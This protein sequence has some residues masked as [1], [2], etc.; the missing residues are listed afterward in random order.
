MTVEINRQRLL[1]AVA[2]TIQT[3]LRSELASDRA[4]AVSAAAE[5]LLLRERAAATLE[6]QGEAARERATSQSITRALEQVR[7]TPQ[8]AGSG[9]EISQT[10]TNALALDRQHYAEF[11]AQIDREA[12]I[13]A[14][15]TEA[16]QGAAPPVPPTEAGLLA[17]L[18]SRFPDKETIEVRNL[19]ALQGGFSKQTILFDVSFD[20]K[21][22]QLVMRRD[23]PGG[24]VGTT[25]V[26]EFDLLKALYGTGFAI[27]EPL[28]LERDSAIIPY[29]FLV[30]RRVPGRIIGDAVGMREEVDFDPFPALARELARLHS[31]DLNRLRV[32]GYAPTDFSRATL[33]A[34]VEHWAQLYE[35]SVVT[36]CAALNIAIAW[37]RANIDVGLQQEVVLV[38][39]DFGFHNILF[40]GARFAALVDWELAHP[41]SPA[42]D[43]AYI[44]P[45]VERS[46]GSFDGFLA[47]YQRAGGAKVTTEAL[48]FYEML[49]YVRNAAVGTLS[50]HTF[51]AGQHDDLP[52]ARISALTFS[53]YVQGIGKTLGPMIERHG[54]LTP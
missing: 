3:T 18:R 20:G 44:R 42:E 24:P 38:H 41:G 53:D 4:R 21:L 28:W 27:A 29:P 48:C 43:L 36:P 45:G 54:F 15:T 50:L 32:P 6:A 37:L 7:T 33:L 34:T 17:Y 46:R 35:S 13:L 26:N 49:R 12:A 2:R 30:S 47:D 23:M 1:A 14:R 22:E 10:L 39:S 19:N 31:T 5:Y 11:D 40:D 51:N 8:A 25:V 9:S 16:S 52:L